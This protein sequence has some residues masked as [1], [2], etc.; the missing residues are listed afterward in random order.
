MSRHQEEKSQNKERN[1]D[2]K[3]I[4]SYL[5]GKTIGEGTFGKVKL[6]THKYT[7]ENV[8]IKIESINEDTN[9][10]KNE[11]KIYQ[12]LSG[13]NYNGIPILKW[14]GIDDKYNYMVINLFMLIYH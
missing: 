4:G 3:Q 1:K 10:L 13:F 8:A 6:A 11:T 5:L 2:E 12:Y 14:Y 9:L 7:N